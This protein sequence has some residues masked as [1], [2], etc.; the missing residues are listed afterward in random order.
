MKNYMYSVNICGP[1]GSRVNTSPSRRSGRPFHNV[2]GN[3]LPR[4]ALE[5]DA[6]MWKG[7]WKKR[8]L[9]WSSPLVAERGEVFTRLGHLALLLS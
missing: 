2:Q 7:L 1:F 3:G 9:L 4:S 8:E 5:L 6:T